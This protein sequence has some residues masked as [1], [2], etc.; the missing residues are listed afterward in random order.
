[1]RTSSS[2]S[3]SYMFSD[4][5]FDTLKIGHRCG[6]PYEQVKYSVIKIQAFWKL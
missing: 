1:M 4:L 6:L 2:P 3:E 5:M